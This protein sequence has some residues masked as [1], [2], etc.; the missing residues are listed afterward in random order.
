LWS[1][2]LPVNSRWT[3][4]TVLAAGLALWIVLARWTLEKAGSALPRVM[5]KRL[6]LS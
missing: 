6:G 5:M 3:D 1:A 4:L 2:Y